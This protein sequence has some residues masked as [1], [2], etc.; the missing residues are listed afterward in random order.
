VM[1]P[2]F[3][4]RITPL[5][6]EPS[7]LPQLAFELLT[8]SHRELYG[9]ADSIARVGTAETPLAIRVTWLSAA[10]W[11]TFSDQHSVLLP[12]PIAGG[13]T[14]EPLAWAIL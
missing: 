10:P 11:H 7:F 4:D 14:L 9:E 2:W 8:K 6:I 3:A 12:F 13:M 1:S 5:L